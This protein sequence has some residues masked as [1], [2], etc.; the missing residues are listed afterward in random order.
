M[1]AQCPQV[2]DQTHHT[3][4]VAM[5]AEKSTLWL[6]GGTG[7]QRQSQLKRTDSEDQI[8][9]DVKRM[10]HP[11]PTSGRRLESAGSRSSHVEKNA[12]SGAGR[13]LNDV[14]Q[15]DD[16]LG[17]LA[18]DSQCSLMRKCLEIRHQTHPK[19]SVVKTAENGMWNDRKD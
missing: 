6:N 16:V 5:T 1:G 2:K 3:R 17:T 15:E 13:S 19:C 7:R 4:D 10:D 14:E 18:N 8:S 11:Q 9:A 12:P